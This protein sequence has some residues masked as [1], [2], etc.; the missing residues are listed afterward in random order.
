MKTIFK[1]IICNIIFTIVTNSC[2]ANIDCYEG[3]W[4]LEQTLR[5]TW[6]I[7]GSEGYFYYGFGPMFFWIQPTSCTDTTFDHC[8]LTNFS[9]VK[10]V[11]KRWVE[12]MVA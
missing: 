2:F 10:F 9:T 8:C 5:D 6:A 1:G 4:K 3:S 11:E 7:P 12:L